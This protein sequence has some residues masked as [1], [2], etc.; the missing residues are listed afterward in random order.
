[1]DENIE[2]A[3]KTGEGGE[4]KEKKKK[5]VEVVTVAEEKKEQARKAWE[6]EN[7]KREA[8]GEKIT[9]ED[10]ELQRRMIER[11]KGPL[12]G[13]SGDGYFE[14]FPTDRFDNT[15]LKDFAEEVKQL[16]QNSQI[17]EERLQ[18][19]T[20]LVNDMIGLNSVSEDVGRDFIEEINK[21]RTARDTGQ[22][23][24][25]QASFP[26]QEAAGGQ[27][28]NQTTGDGNFE[29]INITN[30]KGTPLEPLAQ[31]IANLGRAGVRPTQEM[32]NRWINQSTQ[33]LANGQIT[34]EQHQA[35]ES[36][37]RGLFQTQ[38][39]IQEGREVGRSNTP[40]SIQEVCLWIIQNEGDEWGPD[41][42]N[43]LL[44]RTDDLDKAEFSQANFLKW[45]RERMLF[46]DDFNPDDPNLNLLGAVGFETEYRT[47]GLGTMINNKKQYF[48]DRK[49]N[50]VYEDFAD[51]IVNEIFLFST[52]RGFDAQYRYRMWSDEDLPKFLQELHQR[53]IFTNQSQLQ[54]ILKFSAEYGTGDTKV[55]DSIRTAY[56]AY[57]YM[58]DYEK[59]VEKLGE[60]NPFFTRE[61]FENSYRLLN[62]LS[63]NGE[64]P[65]NYQKLFDTLFDQNGR[66]IKSKFIGFVNIFNETGKNQSTVNLVRE[67]LRLAISHKYGLEN[68]L[69]IDPVN[70]A[71]KKRRKTR[72]KNLEYA[73]RWANSMARWTGA[74]ARND[75]GA[76]GYDAQTKTMRF[77]Q[78]RIR[79]SNEERG[80][81][82][83]N[84]YD[85]PILKDL[86]LDFF[87]GIFVEKEVGENRNY[88]PFEIFEKLDEIDA[89]NISDEEKLSLKNPWY[90][91][92]KFKSFTELDY[93]SNHLGRSWGLFHKL[94]GAE[95]VQIDQ[96]VKYEPFRGLVF[97]RGKFEEQVKENFIKPIRY[98]FKTYSNIDYSKTMR[99][100]DLKASRDAGIPV[101][102]DVTVAEAM[103]GPAVLK[104]FYKKGTKEVDPEKLRSDDPVE[105]EKIR[106]KIYKN[107]ARAILAAHIRSHRERGSG[108]SHM[109][110]EQVNMFYE[111]LETIRAIEIEEDGEGFREG[112]RFFSEEDIEWMRKYS[113]TTSGR[114][115]MTDVGAGAAGGAITGAVK[116]IKDFISD[117]FK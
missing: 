28:E 92:L 24:G 10:K 93:A 44:D 18:Q 81:A 17:T 39:A 107:V 49:N 62:D 111:A 16:G 31:Q 115:L 30:L 80:G 1:M 96:I 63:R 100:Q 59:L 19:I 32:V 26:M 36:D 42:P 78:Y 89:M 9:D 41:G 117:I 109:I 48:K 77:Q 23:Y 70:E 114:M 72:R 104:D 79:Q 88:T 86:T 34:P 7:K 40:K 64:I 11:G 98:A 83:G 106:T 112:E 43:A 25:E 54:K 27:G 101:Y 95:E 71:E 45:V 47:I 91:K 12:G 57:Y 51:A 102:K 68:G 21:V 66:P 13:G 37:L 116:G 33:L 84:Q 50:Q 105:H 5:A 60:D 56:E 108:Y 94:M 46:Y 97:D 110:R 74:G 20:T 65:E 4:D 87:N 15:P 76:I 29:N 75:T 3:E 2:K 6:E 53:S 52:S 35:F 61:G 8:K 103:F 67:A 58:S 113:K 22:P 82:F 55:G 69:D 85:L 14:K 73:E 99:V 90:E 38:V